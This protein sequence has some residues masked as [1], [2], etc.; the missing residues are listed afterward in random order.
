M[1]AMSA[2]ASLSTPAF[3]PLYQQIKAL[4]IKALQA[5]EWKAGEA[6]PSEQ[7]LAQ[8]FGVSQGLSLI[9]I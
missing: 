8:R 9:H 5:G 7:D 4:I 1:P 6:I 2:P 3:S